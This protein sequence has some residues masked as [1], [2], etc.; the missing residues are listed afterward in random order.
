MEL[1]VCDGAAAEDIALG[2][3]DGCA[4]NLAVSGQVP[5]IGTVQGVVNHALGGS[6]GGLALCDGDGGGGGHG[7]CGAGHGGTGGQAG[8]NER[9][10]LAAVLQAVA[11]HV[12]GILDATE[13]VDL[14]GGD[15]GILYK[16]SEVA[17]RGELTLGNGLHNQTVELTDGTLGQ[18]LTAQRIQ[19][20]PLG[21]QLQNLQITTATTRRLSER[22]RSMLRPRTPSASIVS[23]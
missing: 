15:D 8:H 18:S 22:R 2:D 23:A 9:I 5:G 21:S 3:G 19:A 14:L 11:V 13:G 10:E 4:V 17:V 20:D 7:S 6:D 16:D 12:F 1:A